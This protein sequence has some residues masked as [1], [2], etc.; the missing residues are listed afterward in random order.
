MD[1]YKIDR[2]IFSLPR[3]LAQVGPLCYSI[4]SG[5][6]YNMYIWQIFKKLFEILAFAKE[7]IHVGS[8]E[9]SFITFMNSSVTAENEYF[10]FVYKSSK[11]L[12]KLS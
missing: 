12:H 8:N 7:A 6:G 4:L 1:L 11:S 5:Y 3:Y 2:A 10:Q 9:Q